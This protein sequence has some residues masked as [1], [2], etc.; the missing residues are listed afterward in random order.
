MVVT[1]KGAALQEVVLGSSIDIYQCFRGICCLKL[2]RVYSSVLKMEAAGSFKTLVNMYQST[3]HHI[4]VG[5]N[6]Y[7]YS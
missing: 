1:L 7:R 2:E 6:L 4:P 3:W 5:N